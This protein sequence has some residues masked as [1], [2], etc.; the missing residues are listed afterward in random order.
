MTEFESK[1]LQQEE[2]ESKYAPKTPPKEEKKASNPRTKIAIL[3]AVCVL[4][5]AVSIGGLVSALNAPDAAASAQ[6]RSSSSSN[7]DARNDDTDA[8]ESSDAESAEDVKDATTASE[9]AAENQQSTGEGQ[10]TTE[11]AGAVGAESSGG[12][13]TGSG[14]ST[15][16]QPGAQQPQVVNVTMT[17]SCNEAVN[18][19]DATALAVSSNGLIASVPMRL[20]AGSTVYDA[21]AASGIAFNSTTSSLGIFITAIGGLGQPIAGYPQSGWKYYINGVAAG[22]SCNYYTLSDGDSIE[23]R[24]ALQA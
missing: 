16:E 4:V 14:G 3:A 15:A 8:R 23:W 6:Q 24:Y 7:S 20:N 21:L 17:V 13:A 11:A 1:D 12:N 10:T 18:V 9:D 2:I 22:S 19:G 5:L